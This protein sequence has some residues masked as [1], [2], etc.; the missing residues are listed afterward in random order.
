MLNVF[1][2]I[3]FYHSLLVEKKFDHLP[4]GHVYLCNYIYINND[5]FS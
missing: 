5:Q 3:I 1:I 2:K 4:D